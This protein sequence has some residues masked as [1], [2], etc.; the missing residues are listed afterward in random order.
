MD[1]PG[2]CDTWAQYWPDCDVMMK[3]DFY[4][5]KVDLLVGVDPNRARRR[6]S[7]LDSLQPLQRYGQSVT[8]IKYFS[9]S[10][11]TVLEPG[12]WAKNPGIK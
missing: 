10:A 3:T 11:F 6:N 5:E 2:E 4:E 12:I 7:S 9:L 8:K 1:A